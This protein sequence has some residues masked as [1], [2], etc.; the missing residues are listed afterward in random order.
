[1]TISSRISRFLETTAVI[2]RDFWFLCWVELLLENKILFL[3]VS[4]AGFAKKTLFSSFRLQS[5]YFS[6]GELHTMII[7]SYIS[8]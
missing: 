5:A 7:F 8:S 2:S 1:M 3:W 4:L 6:L